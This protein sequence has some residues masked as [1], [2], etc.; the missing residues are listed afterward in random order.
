MSHSS[1]ELWKEHVEVFHQ[2]AKHAIH[3]YP[4]LSQATVDLLNY[5]EN[6]TYLVKNVPTAEKYVLRVCRPGYHTKAEIEG[7]VHWI[8]SIYQDTSVEVSL[9][10]AGKNGE[11]IQTVQLDSDSQEYCCVLFTFLEGEAPDAHN[12]TELVKQFELIG[13][14]SAHFHQHAIDN[15]AAFREIKRPTWDYE[16]I[17]G[18]RPIWGRWQDGVAITPERLHLFQQVADII[19]PRLDRFGKDANRF[20]L[21]HADLRNTNLLVLDEQ[22]KVIDFD[23]SGFGWYLFDLASS[24]TFIE[25][26][27]YV[28]DLIQAWLKGYRKVRAL[29]KEEELEIPTFIMMRRLQLIAWIGSRENET[30]RELGG[31]YTEQTDA[32]A[33]QYL[34]YSKRFF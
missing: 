19:K 11:Y 9:P 15:W 27:P 23:D 12:E 26:K 31:E 22:V 2:V 4:N 18:E 5:S 32:L 16:T 25:H 1:A 20:G 10:I 17:L 30:T 21:I 34:E 7:E 14:I 13:E 29:S 8:S 6:A 24:L 28:P 33:R 3:S